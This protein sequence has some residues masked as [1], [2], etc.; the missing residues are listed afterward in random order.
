MNEQQEQIIYG[1]N[2]VKE[3]IRA[4]IEIERAYLSKKI[5]PAAALA[6]Q[7]KEMGIP[8]ID[9]DERRM[10]KICTSEDGR[11]PNHQGIAV[12]PTAVKYYEI[13]DILDFAEKKQEDAL[14][15]IL[16]GITDP[17]N[18]GAI[19]RSAEALGVHGII[20]PKRR[21]AGINS[22]VYK[23]SAGA[24]AHMRVARVPNIVSTIKELKDK[25]F[26]VAGTVVGA[27]GIRQANLTGKLAICIGSEGEG[28]SRLVTENCDFVFGIPLLGNTQSLNAACAATVAI[29]EAVCQREAKEK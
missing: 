19:I 1:I 18:L 3:A 22:A 4:G 29:Y 24:A 2:P 5:G 12:I 9:A 11:E 6:M 23:S 26:W 17:N 21:S 20:V 7:L 15:L 16:D 8:V 25:G 13:S 14:I 10:A 28:L 27:D